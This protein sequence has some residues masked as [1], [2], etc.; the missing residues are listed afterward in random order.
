VKEFV[1]S[2]QGPVWI[3]PFPWNGDDPLPD[4]LMLFGE[5]AVY[6]STDA[7]AVPLAII[8]PQEVQVTGAQK[9]WFYTMIQRSS[10]GFRSGQLPTGIS[11]FG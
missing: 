4:K 9:Q 6:S 5:T 8:S 1:E 2:S 10:T 3:S 7:S 11:A